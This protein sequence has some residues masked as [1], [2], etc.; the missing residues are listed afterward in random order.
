MDQ[1]RRH[2]G[3]DPVI[4]LERRLR[5]ITDRYTWKRTFLFAALLVWLMRSYGSLAD[6][7]AGQSYI[8]V[9]LLAAIG[10]WTTSGW[11]LDLPRLLFPDVQAF[12]HLRRPAP[13]QHLS[14]EAS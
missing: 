3:R 11:L 13:R 2:P 7:V 5:G 14:G 9:W 10:C 12:Q 4:D 1:H 6:D 8:G